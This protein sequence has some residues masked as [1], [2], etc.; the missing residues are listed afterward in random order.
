MKTLKKVVSALLTALFCL[1]LVGCM[2]VPAI[3]AMGATSIAPTV[4][5]MAS[6]SSPDASSGTFTPA[7]PP[8]NFDN[9][10]KAVA[11]DIG[12]QVLSIVPSGDET[13]VSLVR[14]A[15]VSGMSSALRGLMGKDWKIM[16]TVRYQRAANKIIITTSLRGN[17]LEESGTADGA[18][19]TI[20]AGLAR[21]FGE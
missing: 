10:I 20:K 8:E 16:A 5:A 6:P 7:A 12:Y 21:K 14:Q 4:G 13:T 2:S 11:R 1:S 15:M 9:D 3:Y 17:D 19:T 18:V